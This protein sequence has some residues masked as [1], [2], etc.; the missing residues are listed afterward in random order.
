VI[1][2]E[3]LFE[4]WLSVLNQQAT[5]NQDHRTERLTDRTPA[6]HSGPF[7]FICGPKERLS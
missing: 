3:V 7:W 5:T 2:S 6:S 4:L 1:K